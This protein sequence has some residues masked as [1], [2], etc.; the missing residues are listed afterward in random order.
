MSFIHFQPFFYLNMVAGH[1][2]PGIW[3]F[4][5]MN[6]LTRWFKNSLLKCSWLKSSWLKWVEKIGSEAWGWKVWGWNILQPLENCRQY[7]YQHRLD[8]HNPRKHLH[9]YIFEGLWHSFLV[10]FLLDSVKLSRKQFLSSFS[11]KY[12][13]L[14]FYCMK[15]QNKIV[16]TL[17]LP[18]G[19]VDCLFKWFKIWSPKS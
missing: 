8:C 3:N 7:R 5:I 12:I 9:Q 15:V 17:S 6:F 18:L 14:S 4:P 11:C 16:Q 19:W 1:F 2:T 10:W 13:K